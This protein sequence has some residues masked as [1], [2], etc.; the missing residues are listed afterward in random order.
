[1]SLSRRVSLFFL[2][3]LA[4]VLAGFSAS[5][6]AA[7]RG[8]LDRQVDDRLA[9]GLDTLAAACEV[10]PDGVEWEP[11]E[12][13]LTLGVGGG[14]EEVRW[15]VRDGDGRP[16]GQSA[17]AGP[18]ADWLG[19]FSLSAGGGDAV[20]QADRGGRPWRLARASSGRPPHRGATC[21]RSGTGRWC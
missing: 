17:N 3:A 19:E 21:G 8:R 4:L 1:M 5:L 11:D 13:R 18:D 6:Y 10:G 14:P 16:V 2:A 12:H 7:T 9:A 20:V 15:A